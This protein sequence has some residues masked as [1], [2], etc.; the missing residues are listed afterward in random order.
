MGGYVSYTQESVHWKEFV[1]SSLGISSC[2]GNIAASQVLHGCPSLKQWI[3]SI[4]MHS[5]HQSKGGQP[6]NFHEWP[7]QNFSL[8]YQYNIKYTSDKNKEKYQL[9]DYKL[10]QSQILQTNIA[11]TVWQTVGRIT[12][13]ILGVKG[14]KMQL[15]KEILVAFVGSRSAHASWIITLGHFRVLVVQWSG[16]EITRAV[17]GEITNRSGQISSS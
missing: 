16:T 13:E 5:N 9:G 17:G 2:I 6:F 3:G 4:I 15:V 10:I 7:W 12:Y 11:R 14:L 8:H 1:S